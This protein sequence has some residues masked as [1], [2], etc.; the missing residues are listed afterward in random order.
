MSSRGRPASARAA[1]TRLAGG[2]H[3]DIRWMPDPEGT[4]LPA[5][6]RSEGLWGLG[7]AENL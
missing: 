6:S 1:L 5:G 4:S 7:N 2:D 3:W